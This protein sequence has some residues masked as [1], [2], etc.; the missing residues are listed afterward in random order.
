VRENTSAGVD[1]VVT[2]GATVALDGSGSSDPEG[3]IASYQW[4]QSGGPTVSLTGAT[5]VRPTFVAPAVATDTVLTFALAV[6]D[7]AGAG[8]SAAVRV[9]VRPAAAAA[10]DSGGGG[11]TSTGGGD[12]GLTSLSLLG[13]AGWRFRRRTPRS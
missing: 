6:A 13:L 7:A 5:T 11:C 3:A 10:A 12:M 2:A 1:Q 9:T 8:S 4:S